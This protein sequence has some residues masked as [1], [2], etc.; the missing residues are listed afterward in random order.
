VLGD[1]PRQIKHL[2]HGG[3]FPHDAVEIEV[4][5][6]LFFQRARMRL[7]MFFRIRTIPSTLFK[8]GIARSRSIAFNI[9]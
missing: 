3:A 1:F 5:Q 2:Q 8:L 6:Q 4:R 9:C 7:N